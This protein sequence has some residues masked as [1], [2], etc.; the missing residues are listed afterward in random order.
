MAIFSRSMG[1]GGKKTSSKSVPLLNAGGNS[2]NRAAEKF[3]TG[4]GATG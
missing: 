4:E 3:D 1:W 2:D